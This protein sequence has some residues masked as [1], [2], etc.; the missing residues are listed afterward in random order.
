MWKSYCSF[1]S[2]SQGGNAVVLWDRR[3]L[4]KMN[5][6]GERRIL[7]AAVV[8]TQAHSSSSWSSSVFV[9]VCTPDPTCHVLFPAKHLATAQ[10]NWLISAKVIIVLIP[11][12][13]GWP[14]K[15]Y[16]LHWCIST[17]SLPVK[18]LSP[19]QTQISCFQS[20]RKNGLICHLATTIACWK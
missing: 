7:T 18:Y 10:D 9:N 13:R 1:L 16:I 17:K 20:E 12:S 15:P 6:C 4:R 5:V 19:L 3:H 8:F 11:V 14:P 2:G